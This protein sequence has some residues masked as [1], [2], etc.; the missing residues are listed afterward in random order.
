MYP[1]L[2]K[3]W[4]NT[5][6][7]YQD[8]VLLILN[9]RVFKEVVWWEQEKSEILAISNQYNNTLNDL[10]DSLDDSSNTKL[11]FMSRQIV[12]PSG[13]ISDLGDN[14]SGFKKNGDFLGDGLQRQQQYSSEEIND[15]KNVRIP[16]VKGRKITITTA[17]AKPVVGKLL[18]AST[19]VVL[20]EDGRDVNVRKI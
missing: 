9:K 8:H 11:L 2:G 15:D 19:K 17:S 5:P 16:A 10:I 12:V 4:A 3:I 13:N 1:G 20:I 14:A 6:S 18:T 7:L